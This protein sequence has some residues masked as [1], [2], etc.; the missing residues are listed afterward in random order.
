[1]HRA[2]AALAIAF[3][4]AMIGCA[5]I[6]DS[7]LFGPVPASTTPAPTASTTPVAP[8]P[9]ATTPP[10]MTPPKVAPAPLCTA[11]DGG[12]C[13]EQ[14]D[15]CAAIDPEYA[16]TGCAEGQ[17]LAAGATCFDY[18]GAQPTVEVCDLKAS[19]VCQHVVMIHVSCCS[20]LD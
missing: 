14:D 2:L 20:R 9:T 5:P 4:A 7:D 16:A 18:P 13:Q 10:A 15:A 11:C 1:M 17:V 12:G 3:L 6:D 8:A 19:P